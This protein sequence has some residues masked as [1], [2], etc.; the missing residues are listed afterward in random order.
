MDVWADPGSHDQGV[1]AAL[2]GS[3]LAHEL[4][5]LAAARA[6]GQAWQQNAALQ[7]VADYWKEF[8]DEQRLRESE[9][10]RD[11]AI[12]ERDRRTRAALDQKRLVNDRRFVRVA[13][14]RQEAEQHCRAKHVT[15]ML[16]ERLHEERDHHRRNEIHDQAQSVAAVFQAKRQTAYEEAL[17][18]AEEKRRSAASLSR[19]KASKVEA[20]IAER[21]YIRYL[22][23]MTNVEVADGMERFREELRQQ[24]I[25][26]KFDGARLAK[27]AALAQS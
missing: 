14:N 26:S 21:D 22:R 6:R 23:R 10:R 17:R 15:K 13:A 12:Q 3:T 27:T 8:T 16:E 24:R 11:A 5:S 7:Q 20:I 2:Q 19:S 18:V 25:A 1:R 4:Q 9:A